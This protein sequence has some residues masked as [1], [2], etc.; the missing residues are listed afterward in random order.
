MRPDRWIRDSH[1]GFADQR[2]GADSRSTL[3]L[4]RDG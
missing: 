2:V 1:Q 4:R 3:L